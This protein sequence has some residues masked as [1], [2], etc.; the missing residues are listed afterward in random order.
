M[1]T[2]YGPAW[3]VSAEFNKQLLRYV[4]IADQ[5]LLNTLRPPA[6]S[7]QFTGR[8]EELDLITKFFYER[9][10][11]DFVLTG[12]P[13][14]GKT[15]LALKCAELMA[16]CCSEIFYLDTES[17]IDV[18]PG[19]FMEPSLLQAEVK[20]N[21]EIEESYPLSDS[22]D[23]VSEA[24]SNQSSR[25]AL[26]IFDGLDP[27]GF[28]APCQH[29]SS[30]RYVCRVLGYQKLAALYLLN[31]EQGAYRDRLETYH[32]SDNLDIEAAAT[33]LIKS[34]DPQSQIPID[35]KETA[36]EIA[37]VRG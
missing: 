19:I 9:L 28:A 31:P 10:E 15:Q 33:L 30:R 21:A 29:L 3:A 24:I 12:A 11:G 2:L 1:D 17:A 37:Q 26:V 7:P 5:S 35:D 13:G 22:D 14:S 32:L 25:V 6:P 20:L 18:F 23:C 16:S 34:L 4:P 27:A 36:V 8:T